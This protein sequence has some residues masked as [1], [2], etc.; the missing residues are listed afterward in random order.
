[1]KT[2]QLDR[3]V[4]RRYKSIRECDLEL[5][6]LNVLIGPN[7]AGKSNFIGFLHM[8]RQLV[9]KKLRLHIS[10]RGG[11]NALLHFGTRESKD[12]SA[13]LYFGNGGYRFSLEP[14]DEYHMMFSSECLWRKTS[15]GEKIVKDL[16]ESHFETK[17]DCNGIEG[18]EFEISALE[19]WRV[20]HFHDTSDNALL[21]QMQGINDNLYLRHDAANLAP[22]LYLLKKVHSSCYERIVETIQKVA[23]FFDDFLLRPHPENR[24]MITLEW[25]EKKQEVSFKTSA[26]SDGT[27][28][29]ICLATVLLQPEEFRP[30]TIIIDEPEIGLHPYAISMLA[31]LLQSASITNQVIIATQSINLL[32]EF[33]PEDVVVADRTEGHTALK[34]LDP[35][36][37]KEWLEEYSLGD[38]WHKNLLGGG[39]SR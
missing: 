11:A 29:F 3:I 24:E 39:P 36:P 4:L 22:F 5:K 6:S 30:A 14:A 31:A 23:P 17:M 12:M 15:T 7:G 9:E 38:L 28:R 13:E 27:L 19:G 20:Y 33:D 16:G 1:M 32:D 18:K 21:R 26:L 37:L 2:A 10:K 34:R 35:G 8:I 25:M